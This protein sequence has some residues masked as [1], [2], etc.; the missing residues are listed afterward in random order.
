MKAYFLLVGVLV[1]AL[2][3]LMSYKK[4]G[5]Q[6]GGEW[7]VY[8]TMGCGWTRKQLD[9]LSRMVW[10]TSLLSGRWVSS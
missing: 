9:H 8:G 5:Y 10:V 7:V 6:S 1:L 4:T 3:F 2:V